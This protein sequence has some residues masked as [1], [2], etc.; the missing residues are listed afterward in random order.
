V[1]ACW[2]T[3]DEVGV[4]ILP[5]D[6]SDAPIPLTLARRPKI[7]EAENAALRRRLSE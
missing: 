4:E 1:R 7:L 3:L 2:R 6:A 5:L